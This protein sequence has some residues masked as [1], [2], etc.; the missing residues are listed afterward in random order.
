[1]DSLKEQRIAVKF[2]V[3][4]GKSATE[5]FAM[6]NTVY[7][8]VALKRTACFKSH[9]RFKGGRQSTDDDERSGCPSTS[10]DDPHVDQINTLVRSNR[11]LTIRELAEEGGI[12]VG[13][14]YEILTAKLKVHRRPKS[15]SRPRLSGT[16]QPFR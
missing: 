4:R 7:G 9:E 16:A 1:M 14:C 11:R 15:Q 3:K 2:C 10:T 5:I 12:T 13:S 6:L 8:N